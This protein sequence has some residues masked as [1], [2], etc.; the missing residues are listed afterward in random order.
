MVESHDQGS[1]SQLQAYGQQ[2]QIDLETKYIGPNLVKIFTV[3][4][5]HSQTNAL[6]GKL[7]DFGEKC[8]IS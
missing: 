7:M 3:V 8:E 2:P 1:S 6:T 4:Q 5:E